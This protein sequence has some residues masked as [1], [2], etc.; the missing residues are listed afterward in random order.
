M[1][2]LYLL[3]RYLQWDSDA[4][5]LPMRSLR[6]VSLLSISGL[7]Y[8]LA[9]YLLKVGEIAG[10]REFATRTLKRRKK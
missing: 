5:S 7:G 6:L 8:L 2:P 9:T 10:L 4:A 1:L 3:A